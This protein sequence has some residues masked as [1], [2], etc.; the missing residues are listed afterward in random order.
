MTDWTHDALAADLLDARHLAGD[1]AIERLAVRGGQ[2]D[3]AAMRLSWSH[4]MI[5][6]YEVKISRADFFADV[7]PGKYRGYLGSV[8]RLYFAVP[9]G[10]I[11]AREVPTEC[12]LLFRG[13][14]GWYS[15]RK[16]PRREL[17]PLRH[18][19][20]V[21][22]LLFRHYPAAWDGPSRAHA[23]VIA[24]AT[25][26]A[27]PSCPHPLGLHGHGWCRRCH[28]YVENWRELLAVPA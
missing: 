27:C 15:R 14:L 21:Q 4:P 24:R 13:K 19:G 5:T 18:I 10:L 2:L 8:E 1:I 11:D 26:P 23:A 12:G 16:P 9:K 28:C 25:T 6:G 7:R 20:F 3:V 17:E 22:S